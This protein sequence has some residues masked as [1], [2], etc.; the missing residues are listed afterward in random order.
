M[1]TTMAA[2]FQR[3]KPEFEPPYDRVDIVHAG[4]SAT[5]TMPIATFERQPTLHDHGARNGFDWNDN[6]PEIPI[7]PSR[8]KSPAQLP[9]ATRV[10]SVNEPSAAPPSPFS[11][12]SA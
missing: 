5:S 11:S 1:K 2:D 4:Q 12:A 6:H 9:S 8:Q 3:R 7:E 10:N